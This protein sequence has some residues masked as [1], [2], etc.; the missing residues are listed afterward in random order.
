[1]KKIITKS[2]ISI[3]D[4]MKTLSKAGR[5]CLVIVDQNNKLEGTLS[6]GDLR[7]AILSGC[8][9]SQSIN[10]IFNRNSTSLIENEYDIK[11]VKTIFTANKFDLIPIIDKN[12]KLKDILFWEK[13]FN[14]RNNHLQSKLNIPVVIMA[15]GRGTR[16]EPFTKVLP[17]PLIPIHGEPVI[18]HIIERFTVHGIKSFILSINYKSRI[19]KAYF[20]ELKPNYSYRFIDESKPLGT[21]GAIKCLQG[22]INTPFFVTNCDII[23]DIDYADFYNF[24][25]K[26]NYDLTLVASMKNYSIPYGT[27]ELDNEG[28]LDIINEKPELDFLINAGLYIISPEIL[29]YIPDDKL[30]NITDLI[31][32][33]KKHGKNIGVYPVD[34]ESW[35]DIG[36][37][38]EYKKAVERL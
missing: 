24:H 7:K 14:N 32:D 35:I 10:K 2:D 38:S 5:K 1:M 22:D 33:S 37:W 17:K 20:E 11:K 6:D 27:C 13:L 31:I 15:G 26:N 30:Y 4:A 12:R 29:E 23:L 28:K 9:V 19:M 8:K 18:E 16:M 34:D 25:L 3:K 36:H 21:V